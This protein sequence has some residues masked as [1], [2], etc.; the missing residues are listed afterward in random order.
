[1]IVIGLG[2]GRTGTASL[3]H[4]IGSQRGAICFH[5]LNPTGAVFSGNPQPMLNAIRE[6]QAILDGGDKRL[7]ALDY[8]RPASV[9]KYQELQAIPEVRLMGDIA[10]YYL[11]YVDDILA[12]NQGV[13]FV[14]IKRD[15]EKT[16]ESWMQKSSI[17][18][19]RSLRIADRL[20]SWITRSPYHESRNFWQEHDGS[21]YQ[22]DPVWDKTFPK[23]EATSKRE[24][25]GKYWDFYYAGAEKLA[26]RHPE[27]FRIFP[28]EMMSN[29][30]GQRAILE[31]IGIPE[32]E[33]VLKDSFH[34][35]KSKPED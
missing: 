29:R 2:S 17:P 9:K 18:R 28:I 12:I 34:M 31:F 16:I 23:F 20:K 25:I 35:H 26:A 1:M 19:W 10:Y 4:L 13:R 27:H 15:R 14:C 3:S 33:M 21:V 11:S 24:A 30:D 22:H 5:E 8:A 6:F 7:L 32:A